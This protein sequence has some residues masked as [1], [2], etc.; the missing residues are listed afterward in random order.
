VKRLDDLF[1][2]VNEPDFSWRAKYS[3]LL[4]QCIYDDTTKKPEDAQKV[5]EK[6]WDT[7]RKKEQ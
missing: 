3:W 2:E 1:E 5:L 4:F 7:T 6:L